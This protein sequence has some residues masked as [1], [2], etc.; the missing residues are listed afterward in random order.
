M[1]DHQAIFIAGIVEGLVELTRNG[2]LFSQ[3]HTSRKDKSA[4]QQADRAI[5]Y[6]TESTDGRTR[7]TVEAI[8]QVL[9]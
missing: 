5:S 1:L 6:K 8:A 3:I 4:K 7:K 9:L 2:G